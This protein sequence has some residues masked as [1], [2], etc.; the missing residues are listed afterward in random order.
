MAE[1][2][3]YLSFQSLTEQRL[4]CL[5]TAMGAP[6]SDW[7]CAIATGGPLSRQQR[8]QLITL[9]LQ[10][11]YSVTV[12]TITGRD[13]SGRSGR[14]VLLRGPCAP[15]SESGSTHSRAHLAAIGGEQAE[16]F[17]LEHAEPLGRPTIGS[18]GTSPQVKTRNWL[19]PAG[20]SQL[21]RSSMSPAPGSTNGT[22]RGVTA[23]CSAIHPQR[24]IRPQLDTATPWIP[25]Y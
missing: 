20:S 24:A 25:G 14:G 19:T 16:R 7:S 8:I 11:A 18:A 9:L 10:S 3:A 17:A 23:S 21:G 6:G 4:R 22:R 2:T 12:R 13:R 15:R 1:K 5:A